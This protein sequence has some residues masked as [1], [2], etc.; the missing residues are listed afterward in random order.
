MWTL[1]SLIYNI[2]ATMPVM[3]PTMLIK[4]GVLEKALPEINSSNVV[5]D[6]EEWRESL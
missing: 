5:S 4:G 6:I 3:V 2:R 1:P